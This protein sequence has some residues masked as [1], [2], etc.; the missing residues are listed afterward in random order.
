[1]ASPPLAS[2][3]PGANVV[4][5]NPRS[6]SNREGTHWRLV[7]SC[8]RI[9]GNENQTQNDSELISPKPIGFDGDFKSSN[10]LVD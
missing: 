1:M 8:H 10:S 3:S 7:Q 9:L 6:R 5:A 4:S 2:S